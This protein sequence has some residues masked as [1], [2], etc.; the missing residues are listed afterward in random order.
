MK[1]MDKES[2]AE[3]KRIDCNCSDC[4]FMVRDQQKL[5]DIIAYRTR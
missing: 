5:K 2:I 1:N 3:L 4:K